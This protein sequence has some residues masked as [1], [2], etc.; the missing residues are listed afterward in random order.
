MSIGQVKD[1]ALS[2]AIECVEALNTVFR[3]NDYIKQR[4]RARCNDS[5]IYLY[6]NGISYTLSFILSKSSDKNMSGFDKLSLALSKEAI[7]DVFREIRNAAGVSD[8]AYGLY[9]VCLIKALIRLG[10]ITKADSILDV[11][12]QLNDANLEIVASSKL[13]MFAEWL[14]RLAEASIKKP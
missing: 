9:G 14:K 4:F 6:Y 5:L 8:E 3:N 10:I 2:L 7:Q 12:K 13:L 11:L 1:E